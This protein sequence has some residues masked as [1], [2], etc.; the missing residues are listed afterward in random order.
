MRY[1]IYRGSFVATLVFS[2]LFAVSAGA[3]EDLKEMVKTG[4]ASAGGSYSSGQNYGRCEYS[5]GDS[6]T[7]NTDVN[8]CEACTKGKCTVSMKAPGASGAPG[9]G[10]SA[11]APANNSAPKGPVAPASNKN[12]PAKK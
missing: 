8:K 12:A 6:Y 11:L 4:C 2:A 10:A 3:K 7:C 1:G 5:N 9:G